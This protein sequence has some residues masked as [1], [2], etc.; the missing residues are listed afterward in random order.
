MSA[1]VRCKVAADQPEQGGFS[2]AIGAADRE[3]LGA[4]DRKRQRAE[5]AAVAMRDHHLVEGDQFRG[6]RAGLFSAGR[7]KAASGF[8]RGRALP[9]APRCGLRSDGRRC[10]SRGHRCSRRAAVPASS[11]SL[12]LAAGGAVGAAGLV[13]AGLFLLGFLHRTFGVAQRVGGAVEIGL[14]ARASGVALLRESRPSAA[15][16]G[17]ADRRK[18]DDTVD[19]LQQRAVVARDQ[20]SRPA[21]VPAIAPP[22][23]GHRRRDCWWARRAAAGRVPRSTTVPARRA[24]ARRRSAWRPNDPA[25]ARAQPVSASA[26]FDAA[27]QRPVGLR[28]RRRASRRRVRA[29]AGGRGCRRHR[30]P[31]RRS[32]AHQ[33]IARACR[34]SRRDAPIRRPVRC[35]RRSG[36]T[37]ST[38]RSRCGRQ[39]RSARAEAQASVRRTEAAR[40]A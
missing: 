34:S 16:D 31:A 40:Q 3:A 2:G 29:G 4:T 13:A 37:G 39:S 17:D 22:P 15:E 9:Q 30:A 21:G 1:G 23:R 33:P 12:G 32:G 36:A 8:L 27:F 19:L 6:F 10:G 7:S 11:N 28:R 5:Q 38:C 20:R 25:A 14:G 35:R 18:L 24:S 26:S